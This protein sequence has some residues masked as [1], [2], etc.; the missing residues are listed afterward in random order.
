MVDDTNLMT[1]LASHSLSWYLQEAGILLEI[2]GAWYMVQATFRARRR[3]TNMFRGW[4]GFKEIPRIKQVLQNQAR[5]ET[6]GFFLLGTGLLMQ[7]V[8]GFTGSG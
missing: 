3:I 1:L 8:A 5:T 6:I 4:E 2:I 7:F